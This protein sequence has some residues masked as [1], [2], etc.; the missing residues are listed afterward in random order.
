M[1]VP[2]W[3]AVARAAR[4]NRSDYALD[5]RPLARAGQGTVHG[6]VHKPTG[7]RVVM[8]KLISRTEAARA[9]MRREIDVATDLADH[10]RVMPV[11]DY[12]ERSDW[13]VMPEARGSAA[14]RQS[15]LGD[16]DKLLAVVHAVADGLDAAHQLGWVHRDVKPENILHLDGRWV[17][18]DWGLGRRP[19]G[20]TTS[21]DRTKVGVFL[22]TERFAAPE[23]ADD[24]HEASPAADVYSLGQVIGWAVVG[25]LPAPFTPLVPSSGPW[26][27]VVRQAT[28]RDPSLR[29]QSMTEFLRLV[30]SE[31][32]DPPP[33]VAARGDALLELIKD[34]D[35]EAAEEL[36]ALA[37][38]H[39]EEYYLYVDVVS[40]IPSQRVESLSQDE[41]QAAD[42]IVRGFRSHLEES[43]SRNIGFGQAS[44]I[45]KLL[46]AIARGA[47]NS[48]NWSLMEDAADAMFMWDASW[49]QWDARD[50][51]SMW[52]ARLKGEEARVA[53]TC[54]RKRFPDRSHFDHLADDR[55]VD[56]RIRGAV[57]I[58]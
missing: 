44:D 40:A 9:R 26:R 35:D 10:R 32:H 2:E 1:R 24:A 15:V 34:G 57:G 49:D 16:T 7:V 46:L 14:E 37:A 43:G 58:R 42:Q 54:L 19:R 8:K 30:D 13:F 6:C 17:V 23:L 33:D 45:A 22:G 3:K 47:G 5:P 27:A 20:S 11:L 21:P 28:D 4:R 52:L 18:A 25:R 41:P 29:P 50:A 39:R 12:S 31:V 51:I 56:P 53:A 48:E 36:W 38:Q 55:S